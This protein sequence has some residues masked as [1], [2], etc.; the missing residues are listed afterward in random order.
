VWV[1]HKEEFSF[2]IMQK[3]LKK[4]FEERN[5]LEGTG[6]ERFVYIRQAKAFLYG[7]GLVIVNTVQHEHASNSLSAL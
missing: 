6:I 1:I 7:G 4:N 2:S 3:K 5:E